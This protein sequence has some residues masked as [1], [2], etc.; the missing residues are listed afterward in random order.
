MR[1]V[2][3]IMVPEE[4]GAP[5][6]DRCPVTRLGTSARSFA[7]ARRRRIHST[8]QQDMEDA[9][10]RLV[11]ADPKRAAVAGDDLTTDRQA[12]SD[13][14]PARRPTGF[15]LVESLE[16]AFLF[17]VGDARALVRL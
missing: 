8:R 7:V 17:V 2:R 3:K 10:A 13:A 16:H 5:P 14:A 9:A 4:R 11:V 15:R 12:Q 6:S 1:A